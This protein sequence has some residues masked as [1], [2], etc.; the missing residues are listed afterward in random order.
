[1]DD[2][3]LF[4]KFSKEIDFPIRTVFVLSEDMKKEFGI[5]KCGVVIIKRG[6]VAT[7]DVIQL[8]K[9]KA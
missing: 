5:K 3:K 1:M 9:G 6:K 2:L 4:G 7:S 8:P